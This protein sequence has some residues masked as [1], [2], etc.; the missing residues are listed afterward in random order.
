M[1][2][3]AVHEK[4]GLKVVMDWRKCM[5]ELVEKVGLGTHNSYDEW[6]AAL[7]HLGPQ[8]LDGHF[9]ACSFFGDLSIKEMFC[10]LLPL[11]PGA[12]DPDI[13][14]PWGGGARNGTELL[15]I[16]TDLH[17]GARQLIDRIPPHME[18]RLRSA[19]SEQIQQLP[20]DV[21]GLPGY[22]LQLARPINTLDV[23]SCCCWSQAYVRI[24]SNGKQLKPP[25]GWAGFRRRLWHLAQ[26]P[27]HPP[28]G[29]QSSGQR[30]GAAERPAGSRRGP[31]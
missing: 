31:L 13:H 12:V 15:G 3:D 25:A 28:E 20:Q 18:V 19:V 17:G 22:Q 4:Q 29:V 6:E 2:Q 27:R 1:C 16:D 30:A 7:R 5:S 11:F 10:Y 26:K 21:K 24:T 23:E 9:R 8:G 14:V